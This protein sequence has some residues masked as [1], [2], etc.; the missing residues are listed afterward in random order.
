MKEH[1]W[2][3]QQALQE[4]Q[5]AYDSDEVPIGA[6]I[7]DKQGE[8]I[9]RGYNQVQ[10][11]YTQQAH[12]E[13]MAIAEAGKALQDWRLSEC[14][15]FVTLEPCGMCIELIYLSRIEKVVFGAPSPLFGYRL[16][17]AG[18]VQLYKRNIICVD[19]NILEQESAHL[20]KQFFSKKR[21]EKK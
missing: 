14:T 17:K 11:S 19:G 16:D 10:H 1:A 2:Y 4:A 5:K 3:M 20:L 8:I 21:K 12:A 9:G 13:C 15:I 6:V 18:Q 7:V